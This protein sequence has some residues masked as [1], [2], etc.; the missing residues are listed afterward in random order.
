[1]WVLKLYMTSEGLGG[2]FKGDFA[3]TNFHSG[4][5]VFHGIFGSLYLFVVRLVGYEITPIIKPPCAWYS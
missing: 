5:Y 2:M 3:L 1:M 4:R